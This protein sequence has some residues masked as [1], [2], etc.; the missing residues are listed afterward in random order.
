MAC[1]WAVV[2]KDMIAVRMAPDM[3]MAVVG[4]PG[5]F[6]RRRP[7]RTLQDLAEHDCICLRLPTHG[8]LLHWEFRRRGKIANVQVT[9]RLVFNATDLVVAAT[10]AGHGLAWVPAAVVNEPVSAGSLAPVLDDWAITCTTPVEVH[11]PL[12][13]WSWRHC[14][15]RRTSDGHA[16]PAVT[17]QA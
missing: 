7:P 13:H 3:R 10:M 9:G 8:A 11:P 5:Y 6:E 14:A 2:A 1:A 4:S 12:W 17:G 15:H 16:W